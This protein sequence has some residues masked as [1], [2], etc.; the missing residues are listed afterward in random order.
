MPI[1]MTDSTCDLPLE[2]LE[3]LDVT[4]L[5]LRVNFG[6]ESYADKREISNEDFYEKLKASKE[7]PTTSLV[8]VGDFIEAFERHPDD[9]IVVITIAAKLSGTWQSASTAAEELGRKDIYVIDSLSV[10]IGLGMLVKL[11]VSMRD[12]GASGREIADFLLEKAQKL[13]IHAALDT[14]KYLVKGGRLSGFQGAVGSVLSFKPIVNIKDGIVTNIGKERGMK[15]AVDKVADMF[16]FNPDADLGLPV[17]FTH[18]GN[19]VMLDYLAE[20]INPPIDG[21]KYSLGSIV[22]THGGPGLV[23][24][25]YFV[26]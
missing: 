14:L 2:E 23:A 20:K 4:M 18:S 6:L 9:E 26:R 19:V 24:V 12:K 1:I 8:A 22:G 7:L 13:Y 21:G 5:S 11:A 15:N 3:A 10:S 17:S 25:A 16:I